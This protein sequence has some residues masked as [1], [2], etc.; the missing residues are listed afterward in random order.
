[1]SR[2][3]HV[4]LTLLDDQITSPDDLGCPDVTAWSTMPA[5]N[6]TERPHGLRAGSTLTEDF[7]LQKE[8]A[9]LGLRERTSFGLLLTP[10]TEKLWGLGSSQK[11]VMQGHHNNSGCGR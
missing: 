4:V 2:T 1:M 5:E 11:E 6:L 8:V 9:D 7:V 10:I 3:V